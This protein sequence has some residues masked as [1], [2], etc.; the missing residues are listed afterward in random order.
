VL[1]VLNFLQIASITLGTAKCLASIKEPTMNI[2]T[3]AALKSM[4]QEAMETAAQTKAEA[5]KGDQ[6]AIRRLAAQ[7]AN[8]AQS[9]AEPTESTNRG[10]DAKA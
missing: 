3:I 10:L 1:N 4:A 9:A 6:Q 5:T 7:A 2:A 8:N